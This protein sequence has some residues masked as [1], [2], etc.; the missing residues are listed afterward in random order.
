LGHGSCGTVYRAEHTVSGLAMAVKVIAMGISQ[1]EQAQI[2]SELQILHRCQSP[3][4]IDYYGVFFA[5]DKIHICTEFMD[6]GSLDRYGQ[7]PEPVLGVIV[8]QVLQGLEYLASIKIMHRDLKP[9]NILLNTQ[10]QV[11][12]CDFGV[13]R[14]LERSVTATFVGTNAYMAP[15]RVLNQPYDARSD[16]WSLGISTFELA[17]GRSAWKANAINFPLQVIQCIV[18]E[19]PPRLDP[20]QHSAEVCDFV[21]RYVLLFITFRACLQLTGC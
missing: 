9:Q 11:K 18:H 20:A 16:V 7:L 10:G 14:Q 4:I 15:E 6:G 3:V 8:F 21:E 1:D 12:I 5:E 13:S 2:R 17:C 19:P